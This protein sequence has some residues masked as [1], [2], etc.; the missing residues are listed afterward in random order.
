MNEFR[1]TSRDEF[2]AWVRLAT[3][4]F[5]LPDTVTSSDGSDLLS[6]TGVLQLA[7]LRR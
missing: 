2:N 4:M 1:T 6:W 7:Y 5:G 3:L